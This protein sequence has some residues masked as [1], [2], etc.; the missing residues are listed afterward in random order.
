[1]N[2]RR[3]IL[4][5]PVVVSLIACALMASGLFYLETETDHTVRAREL[6]IAEE[7]LRAALGE[8]EQ[9][10]LD[11]AEL[12]A[13]LPAV[14]AAVAAQDDA[15]LEAIFAPGWKDLSAG[16]GIEQLQ[17]HIP[18]ATSLIRIHNLKKR[19]D[20]L[21][22]FRKTV[23]DANAKGVSIKAL[24][25]GRAGIGARGVAV[26]KSGG[27]PVGTVEVGLTIG[28]QFLEDLSRRTG[29]DFEFYSIPDATTETFAEKDAGPTRQA[30]SFEGAPLL[31]AATLAAVQGGESRDLSAEIDGGNHMARAIGVTDYTGAVAG[32][33]TVAAPTAIY[34]ALN[35]TGRWISIG[36]TALSLLVAAILALVFGRSIVAQISALA[37]RT[38]ALAEG[39]TGAPIEGIER[40]DAIG[41]MARALQ[42]F[43]RNLIER[44]QMQEALQAEEKTVRRAEAARLAQ[45][46]EARETRA[47]AEHLAETERTRA[48][49]AMQA[50]EAHRAELARAQ[51][52]D[53]ERI[54]A[55][56]ARGLEA[57]S[58]GDLSCSLDEELP[59]E[60]DALRL[61]FNEAVTQLSEALRK[62]ESSAARVDSEA[63]D[64]A[65]SSAALAQNTE[66]NAAT[67]EQTA[68][69][70]NE[71]TE[72]VRSAATGAKAAR[73]LASVARGNA[74]S[75]VDVVQEAV[76]AMAQIETSSQ[77]ITRITSVI[78]D[79]AFQT[80]LL[81]LN[82]G[83]EAARA[84][85]AGRGF[86]VVASEVRALA[87]R[88]S[89]AAKEISELI[90]TSTTQV[91]SG[92][93]L[94]GE[95]GSALG[96]IV[97]SVRDIFARV[98]EIA[99]SADE[100]ASAITEISS[101]VN[102][103]DQTTQHTAEMSDNAAASGKSLAREGTEL[104]QTVRQF[105]LDAAAPAAEEPGAQFAAE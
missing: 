6:S 84:G 81:A 41:E 5:L 55:A 56:L 1:M 75:G 88:S 46:Q 7:R 33:F 105:R 23:V 8:K 79:I 27:K 18:P 95:T 53:Q 22:A 59:G 28:A 51:L 70:L 11:R 52:A 10:A 71:L 54:V 24:E 26:V 34:D 20:D 93:H 35:V 2:I 80:N 36:V 72:S 3:Q 39:D 69:A 48:A 73:D 91:Q 29:Y 37:R 100:Q 13:S 90:A 14:Q 85:E 31:D 102:Q 19:G 57:L 61:H 50:A 21:S 86:A 30:A 4:L 83:V 68:A 78:D 92:V 16:T 42:V 63:G 15:A 9:E 74:E 32:I 97:T 67:L 101:A 17:F 43:E 60:Y 87:Q 98:G 40:R 76:A 38:A 12:I 47:A 89:E 58:L 65:Q 66:R 99:T 94:V 45:E 103:L 77:A 25:R 104:I 44:A 62:I 96:R 49:E 82:A 64:I